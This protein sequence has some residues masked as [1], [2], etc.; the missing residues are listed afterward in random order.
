MARPVYSVSLSA[1]NLIGPDNV[2]ADLPDG[3]TYV[4]R[5]IDLDCVCDQIS[6]DNISAY[7][8]APGGTL[9]IAIVTFA[10]PAGYYGIP[11][12]RGRFVAPPGFTVL[13]IGCTTSSLSFSFNISGYQ[14]TL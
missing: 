9:Y 8:R 12:W 10:F 5:D 7:V 4:V 6:G 13:G 11:R 14:L 2:E 3:F 1:G